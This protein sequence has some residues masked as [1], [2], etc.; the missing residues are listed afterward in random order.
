MRRLSNNEIE[1]EVR[2]TTN[3]DTSV[4]AMATSMAEIDDVTTKLAIAAN[5]KW[6]RENPGREPA[7]TRDPLNSPAARARIAA[8]EKRLHRDLTY[9]EKRLLLGV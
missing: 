8:E 9:S 4:N 5:E 1:K 7:E 2:E 6:N 3:M